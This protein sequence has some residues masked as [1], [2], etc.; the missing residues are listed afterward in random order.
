MLAHA[1]KESI[2]IILYFNLGIYLITVSNNQFYEGEW[3]HL[4]VDQ[5][6]LKTVYLLLS[7]GV[8]HKTEEFAPVKL[9]E[10]PPFFKAV[11]FTGKLAEGLKSHFYGRQRWWRLLSI[12]MD[13][14]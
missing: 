7:I 12:Q 10:D 5:P 4:Q 13:I 2:Q 14:I 1:E 8:F 3:T 11:Q 6:T 9:R